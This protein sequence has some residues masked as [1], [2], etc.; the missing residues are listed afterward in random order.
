M[1]TYVFLVVSILL[2][3]SSTPNRLIDADQASPQTLTQE[4]KDF[5]AHLPQE[6]QK[7]WVRVPENWNDPSGTKIFVFYYFR[8]AKNP[9][10]STLP[11]VYFNGGPTFSSHKKYRAIEAFAPSKLVPL[12]YLDQ[13]GTGCSS[14]YPIDENDFQTSAKRLMHYASNDI[15][16]DA[17]SIRTKLFGE[18]GKWRAFGQ[19]YGGWIAYRYIV[20]APEHLDAVFVHGTSLMDDWIKWMALRIKSQKTAG[21]KYFQTYPHDRRRL[22]KIRS[23]I[24][25]DMCFSEKDVSICGPAVLDGTIEL[26]SKPSKWPELHGW[27]SVLLTDQNHINKHELEKLVHENIFG[28]FQSNSLAQGIIGQIDNELSVSPVNEKVFRR[29]EEMGLHPQDWDFNELRMIMAIKTPM[30]DVVDAQNYTEFPVR[31]NSLRSSLLR[32]PHLLLNVYYG[33]FDGLMSAESFEDEKKALK[34]LAHFEEQNGGHDG[35][36]VDDKIWKDM[37][38]RH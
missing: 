32:F 15:V 17:E 6:I 19:S 10:P 34:D 2:G 7:G 35:Y 29:L 38:S 28:V 16:K 13:R 36:L 24:T 3:C 31:I 14:Q 5:I 12:V 26:L 21:N 18:N 27:I 30:N 25:P 22:R 11:I 8:P 37:A 23:L 1:R 4:C 33:K 9:T 20:T